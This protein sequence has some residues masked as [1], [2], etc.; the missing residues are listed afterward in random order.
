MPLVR[1]IVFDF[2]RRRRVVL[3]LAGGFFFFFVTSSAFEPGHT[4]WLRNVFF[5]YVIASLGSVLFYSDRVYGW[6]R[7]VLLLPQSSQAA[8]MISWCICVG[9]PTVGVLLLSMPGALILMQGLDS[10]LFAVVFPNLSLGFASSS[11]CYFVFMLAPGNVSASFYRH[12]VSKFVATVLVMGIWFSGMILSLRL[13]TWKP[14]PPQT[15]FLLVMSGLLFS[16]AGFHQF[17]SIA[18]GKTTARDAPRQHGPVSVK[19]ARTT[20]SGGLTGWRHPSVRRMVRQA[21]LA[22]AAV[23]IFLLYEAA[24][25]LFS[26]GSM[27]LRFGPPERSFLPSVLF[28]CLIVCGYSAALAET[29][30]ARLLRTLPLDSVQCSLQ[31]LG[32]GSAAVLFLVALTGGAFLL[33]GNENH[34]V[35]WFL[36]LLAAAGPASLC[37]PI[38]AYMSKTAIETIIALVIVSYATAVCLHFAPLIALSFL[39]LVAPAVCVGGLVLSLV[40]LV[41]ILSRSSRAF[42]SQER[43]KVQVQV[44]VVR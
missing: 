8:A 3:G 14:I 7:V 30:S 18:R 24:T 34:S 32:W 1:R 36:S 2:V 38:S 33:V 27:E 16:A 40:L 43:V 35:A 9:I 25:F 10:T 39:V 21:G 13:T 19:S 29:P 15:C 6:Q 37:V 12:A 11:L 44:H 20:S 42:L 41:Q 31:L 4:G 23:S 28:A 17:R 5:A 26:G 22:L